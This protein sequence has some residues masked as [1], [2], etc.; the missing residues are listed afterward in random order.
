MKAILSELELIFVV[1][2]LST[3]AQILLL[4]L[5]GFSYVQFDHVVAITETFALCQLRHCSNWRW[6]QQQP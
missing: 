4:E 1:Y 2:V 5:A 3:L 6:E